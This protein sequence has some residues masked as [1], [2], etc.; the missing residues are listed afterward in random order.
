[1]RK[2]AAIFSARQ[3]KHNNALAFVRILTGC[4]LVYHGWEV[5]DSSKISE[6]ATWDMFKNLSFAKALVTGGKA[7]EL[8]GGVM[9]CL[10]LLT[11]LATIIIAATMLFITFYI[12]HGKIW[13]DDQYP[14]LFVMLCVIFFFVGA[15]S[16]SIDNLLTQK[17]TLNEK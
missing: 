6:Y 14:F 7:A 10:G 4:F 12:G 16:F 17:F 15:G 5:F 13:Y 1:M 11:K 8:L 3:N 9:F 2:L